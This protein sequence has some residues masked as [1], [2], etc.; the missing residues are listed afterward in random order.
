MDPSKPESKHDFVLTTFSKPTYCDACGKFLWGLVK[1]GYSCRACGYNADWKCSQQQIADCKGVPIEKSAAAPP[2]P[3]SFTEV[4]EVVP[5]VV[6]TS[7][8]PFAPPNQMAPTTPPTPS[9]PQKH[10]PTTRTIPTTPTTPTPTPASQKPTTLEK[11]LSHTARTSA[12]MEKA[13][14]EAKAPLNLFTTTPKNFTRFVTRLDPVVEA[15]D[16]LIAVVTWENPYKTGVVLAVYVVLCLYPMLLTILPQLVILYIIARKYYE[17]VATEATPASRPKVDRSAQYMKNMQFLQN[18]MG[19]YFEMYE[20]FEQT[21]T[22]LSWSNPADTI[23]ALKLTI[24]S[25]FVVL[26]TVSFVPIRYL[27]LV[28]GVSIF[29]YNIALVRSL[30]TTVPAAVLEKLQH[31][32]ER[33]KEKMDGNGIVGAEED[34]SRAVVLFENQRWWA[35]LGWIHYLLTHERPAWTTPSLQPS[36]PK[37]LVHPPSA[38]LEWADEDWMV[39]YKWAEVDDK[40][41][42]YTDHYWQLP[43]AKAGFSSVTRRRKWVRRVKDVGEVGDGE[44][45]AGEAAKPIKGE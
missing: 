22:L 44:M 27:F 17:R 14:K 11:I 26:L 2:A 24:L 6:L 10:R 25:I 28:G 45:R 42:C 29:L 13:A 16:E 21:A 20:A 38:S 39:D 31:S 32:V 3:A 36:P 37:D 19:I 8:I 35:G 34:K 41:W 7:S 30:L 4:P 33:V 15:Q 1:Q 40:G 9:A 18:T 23:Q 5:E 43:R 12:A